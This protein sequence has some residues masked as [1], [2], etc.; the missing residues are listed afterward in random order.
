MSVVCVCVC[1]CVHVYSNYTAA[2]NYL[3]LCD[4]TQSFY[5]A[6][7]FYGLQVLTVDDGN[8]LSL[9]E[10]LVPWLERVSLVSLNRWSLASPG[11]VSTY[12]WW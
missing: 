5:C 10:C 12:M 8:G 9:L 7:Q 11:G 3:T 1:V 2:Y 4:L 6:Y